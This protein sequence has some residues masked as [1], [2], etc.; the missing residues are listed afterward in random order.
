MRYYLIAGEASG[1]MHAANLMEQIK[2]K[3]AEAEFRYWGGDR[4]QKQGGVLVKHYKH[5]AFMG[6]AEVLVNL[7]IIL[8]NLKQ[9]KEDLSEYHPDLLILVDYPGFNLRVAE[10]AHTTGIRVAYYISPQIWAWKENR[11][12]K[13]KKVVDEMFVILPFEKCF[14]QKHNMDVH[15]VGHPLLDELEKREKNFDEA[16]FRRAA[17]LGDRPLIAL[18]P[19]S[20]EQ[21][22]KRMLPVMMKVSR[23]F[24]RYQFVIAGTSHIPLKLYYQIMDGYDVKLVTGQTYAVLQSAEAGLITSGTASLETALFHVPQL[25]MYKASELSYQIA[26]RLVKLDFISIANLVF[27]KEVFKEFIQRDCTVNKVSKELTRLLED[28]AYRSDMLKK[29]ELLEEMLGGTGASQ[30]AAE[31][32]VKMAAGKE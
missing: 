32:M 22:I 14:Y 5:H 6:F 16:D 15:F 7:R 20:R 30:R 17:D 2:K 11:I 13:I 25:V 19:G 10:Y 28:E 23:K 31:S 29:Y 24:P 4:M 12:H 21:E 3:D 8:E 1:D 9:C 26:K 27:K 18:L